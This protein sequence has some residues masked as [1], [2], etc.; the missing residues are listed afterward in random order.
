MND[1]PEL[2]RDPD[3]AAEMAVNAVLKYLHECDVEGLENKRK[4]IE[5]VYER[6][7]AKELF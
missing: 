5:K 1:L 6:I 7:K 3:A 2:H 4:W